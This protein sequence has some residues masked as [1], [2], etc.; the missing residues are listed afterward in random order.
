MKRT[1]MQTTMSSERGGNVAATAG[2]TLAVQRTV[3]VPGNVELTNTGIQVPTG[4]H[5]VIIGYGAIWG[6][7][8]LA[9]PAYA[10]GWDWT[11]LGAGF[12]VPGAHLYAL[13]GRLGD[14][15]FEIG[16]YLET[17]WLGL[18]STLFC[19]PNDD[20]Y[21]NN[22]G[23]FMAVVQIWQS[24]QSQAAPQAALSPVGYWAAATVPLPPGEQPVNANQGPPRDM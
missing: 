3:P 13:C 9:G 22:S 23:Q 11:V 17:D 4:A 10:P 15:S 24:T 16:R 14:Y 1:D 12:P 5:L 6:G 2:P 18:P 20:D 21:G 8:P 7:R 19:M